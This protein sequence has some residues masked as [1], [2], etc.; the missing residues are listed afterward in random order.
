MQK[1]NLIVAKSKNN[2][3]GNNNTLLWKLTDDLKF[4][5]ETTT[6]HCVIMGKKTFESIG[7][8]LDDRINIVLSKSIQE[9]YVDPNGVFFCKNGGEINKVLKSSNF[10]GDAFIIGGGEIYK[11][12]INKVDKMYI[13]EIDQDFEGDTF[14]PEFDESLFTKYIL[15]EKSENDI[16]Y[17]ICL[18]ERI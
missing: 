7:K 10:T 16:N 3:I 1:I 17:K 18:Y 12:V 9:S 11:T 13:T 14:F 2:V 8:K 5:K 15:A 6:G 4:F